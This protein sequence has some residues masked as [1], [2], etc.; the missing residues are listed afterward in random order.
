MARKMGAARIICRLRNT[1]YQHKD[2][3]ITPKQFGIDFVTYPEKAA[4]KEIEMLVRQSSTSE[5]QKFSSK[6]KTL[7]KSMAKIFPFKIF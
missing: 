3:I 5:I 2:A 4:K 7:Y 1:E 6:R